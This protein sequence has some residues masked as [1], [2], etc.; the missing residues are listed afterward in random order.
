MYPSGCRTGYTTADVTIIRDGKRIKSYRAYD[1][2]NY[3]YTRDS[4]TKGKYVVIVKP[5]WLAND[6]KDYAFRLFMP[7]TVK[8]TQS[9]F[10]SQTEEMKAQGG[11]L[12]QE[13]LSFPY[14]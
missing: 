4:W 8:I 7:L 1:F 9:T 6:V 13:S 11:P 5:Y 3:D 10:N 12:L 2:R 14:T